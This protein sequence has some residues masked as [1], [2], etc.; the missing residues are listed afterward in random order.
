MALFPTSQ[1]AH[2]SPLCIGTT[3]FLDLPWGAGW[4]PHQVGRWAAGGAGRGVFSTSLSS[5]SKP[6]QVSYLHH[7]AQE[8][9]IS[10]EDG[11]WNVTNPSV[12]V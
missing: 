9:P 3:A 8:Q 1:S 10:Q 4:R 11:D 6:R 7:A 5:R 12:L 2:K